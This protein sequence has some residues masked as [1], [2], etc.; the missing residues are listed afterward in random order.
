MRL[1]FIGSIPE[2]EAETGQIPDKEH[3]LL[4]KAAKELGYA[5]VKSNH[6]VL[7]GSDSKNTI[8]YHVANGVIQYCEENPDKTIL[9]EIH[10]PEDKKIIFSELPQNLKTNKTFYHQDRNSSHKW[11]VTHIRALDSCD[12]LITLGGSKSTR[13]VGHIAADRQKPVLT[14]ASFGGSSSELY[15]RLKYI[16]KERFGTSNVINCLILPWQTQFADE[17]M[18]LVELIYNTW[19]THP[20]HLYFLSYSWTDPAI[21][22]HIETLLRRNNRNVLRDESNVKSGSRLSKSV[23]SMIEQTDTFIAI[24]SENYAASSWCPHE[25]EYARNR[26][27]KNLKPNRIILIT[28]DDTEVPIRFT[29]VLHRPGKDR[30]QRELSILNLLK[31]EN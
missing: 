2:H 25:L 9:M 23:E 28:V 19:F 6:T 11:I 16:Y 14:I 15:E 18:S 29:D 3:E 4:F 27:V 20:P 30:P 21:A 31:E 22:D 8:D 12:V 7:I 24:W 13:I 17:I 26:Q 1:L 5:A 10:H